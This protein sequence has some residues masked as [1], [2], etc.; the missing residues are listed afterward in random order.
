MLSVLTVEFSLLIKLRTD[1]ILFTTLYLL[2]IWPNCHIINRT[3][4]YLLSVKANKSLTD[5]TRDHDGMQAKGKL[6]F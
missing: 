5:R 1:H 3:Y 2:K 4:V 6:L